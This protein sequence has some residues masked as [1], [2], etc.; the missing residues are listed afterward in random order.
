MEKKKAD[1]RKLRGLVNQSMSITSFLVRFLGVHNEALMREEMTHRELL[2][3]FP[4]LKRTSYAHILDNPQAVYCGEVVLVVDVLNE[5]IP[6]VVADELR[7]LEDM[8]IESV[9]DDDEWK[10]VEPETWTR[11][12]EELP[13]IND[14][15][16]SSMTTY[17]LSC[18][19]RIYSH[20]G[21]VGNYNRVRRELISR[22]DSIQA[23]KASKEHA[24]KK[25]LKFERH[26]DDEY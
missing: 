21:Q 1:K 19:L 20:T 25:T 22:P 15:D 12:S 6:Y 7:Y 5:V 14:Y 16:L 10:E 24:K 8:G 9:M 26:Y 23:N 4:N 11:T 17:D 13:D 2:K 3:M 18:L